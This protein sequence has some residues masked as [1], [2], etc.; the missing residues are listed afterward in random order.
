MVSLFMKPTFVSDSKQ[1]NTILICKHTTWNNHHAS[2]YYAN[3]D[4][5]NTWMSMMPQKTALSTIRFATYVERAERLGCNMPQQKLDSPCG[6]TKKWD[7][8]ADRQKAPKLN[9]G[10]E[11]DSAYLTTSGRIMSCSSCSRI[12]QCHTYSFPPVRGLEGTL[13][14]T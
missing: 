4:F 2:G 14:G 12:W 1:R 11:P 6:L 9:A 10:A 13:N 5:T 3:T 8:P 7:M